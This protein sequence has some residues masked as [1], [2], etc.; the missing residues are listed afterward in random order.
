MST[1][2]VGKDEG[3]VQMLLKKHDDVTEDLGKFRKTIDQLHA[4]ADALPDEVGI[5]LLLTF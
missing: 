1:E 4:T 5:F 2:E 3:T